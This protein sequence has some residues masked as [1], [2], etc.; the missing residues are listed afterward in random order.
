V[1]INGYTGAI[2][3]HYPKSWIKIMF[4]VLAVIAA[5]LVFVTLTHHH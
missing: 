5:V 3:G 2:A 4:A 1:V